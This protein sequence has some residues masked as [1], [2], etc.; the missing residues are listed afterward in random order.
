MKAKEQWA[1]LPWIER[2]SIILRAA[3][4]L[5]KISLRNK[6]GYYVRSR[7]KCDASRN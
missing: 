7:K 2:S 6:C 4:L 3:E 5:L 1:N